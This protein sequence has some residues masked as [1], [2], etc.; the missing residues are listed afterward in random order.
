MTPHLD[1]SAGS[2]AYQNL[3]TFHRV[4]KQ[5]SNT[6]HYICPRVQEKSPPFVH[7]KWNTWQSLSFCLNYFSF[8]FSTWSMCFQYEFIECRYYQHLYNLRFL[9]LTGKQRMP[10]E[11]NQMRREQHIL[12]EAE[13]AVMS[14]HIKLI[15]FNSSCHDRTKKD[16]SRSS[17]S[18]HPEGMLLSF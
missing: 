6:W 18:L 16:P 7:M 13:L 9:E 14:V 8:L 17:A 1:P 11:Q 4:P 2:N 5:A 15:S 3:G 10:V 12:G